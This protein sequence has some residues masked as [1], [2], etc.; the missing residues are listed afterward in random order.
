MGCSLPNCCTSMTTQDKKRIE[1]ALDGL[2]SGKARTRPGYAGKPPVRGGHGYTHPLQT[3]LARDRI[4]YGLW[5]GGVRFHTDYELAFVKGTS[6]TNW[7]RPVTCKAPTYTKQARVESAAHDTMVRIASM[8]GPI[9]FRI[10]VAVCAHGFTL[11]DVAK[12]THLAPAT[13]SKRFVTALKRVADYYTQNI[14]Q[15]SAE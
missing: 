9:D 15:R 4:S 8:L 11:Q 1:D 7:E 6:T 5:F 13:V 10:V 12:E 2:L 14:E 3:M